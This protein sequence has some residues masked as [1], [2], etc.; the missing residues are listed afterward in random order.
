M[1]LLQHALGWLGAV[2]VIGCTPPR[3]GDSTRGPSLTFPAKAKEPN[4]HV[5]RAKKEPPR[6][7]LG[8]PPDP[9]P[10]TTQEFW[11]VEV[12]YRQGKL[13]VTSLTLK[14]FERRRSTERHIGRFAIEL[15][16]GNE[17]VD[18]LRFDLPFLADEP[19]ARESDEPSLSQGLEVSR[20]VLVP[21]SPRAT[22]AFLKDRL[23]G[24]ERLV[25]WPPS[26]KSWIEE[27]RPTK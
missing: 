22:R 2:M 26:S 25:P 27:K 21:N 14:R 20:R 9:K 3:A 23:T 10:L 18:R 11:E 4:A 16:I 13:T 19:V 24:W 6:K 15:W 8:G 5:E 7:R 17:L 1:T 12:T